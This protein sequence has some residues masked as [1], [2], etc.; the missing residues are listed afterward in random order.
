MGCIQSTGV[1]ID[2]SMFTFVEAFGTLIPYREVEL[3]G[4]GKLIC[5]RTRWNLP[6]CGCT[7]SITFLLKGSTCFDDFCGFSLE[8]LDKA[9][10][11]TIR[12]AWLFYDISCLRLVAV[13][14]VL[15]L[16]VACR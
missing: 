5:E 13:C 12:V 2:S 10:P 4:F 1:C 16:R 3:A 15:R 11:L 14:R 6:Y 9:A 7:A 8:A